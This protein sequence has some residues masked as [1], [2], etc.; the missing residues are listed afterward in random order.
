[1]LN[2]D[3]IKLLLL[4]SLNLRLEMPILNSKFLRKKDKI[5]FYSIGNVGY[6][7]SN[8]FKFLGNSVL[9]VVNFIY[10]KTFLNKEIFNL[11]SFDL[12]VFNNKIKPVGL[13]ILIGQSFYFIKNSLMLFNNLK[14]YLEKN[15]RLS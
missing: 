6:F 1:L 14:G 8:Y 5:K 4:I 10:G 3:D 2:L 11:F 13:Q 9:D 7:Y 12:N 15:Y